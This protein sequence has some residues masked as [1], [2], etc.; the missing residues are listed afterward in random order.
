MIEKR[1]Q[2]VSK[3]GIVWTN[4]FEY[5][6]GGSEKLAELQKNEKVQLKSSN[7][8]NEFRLVK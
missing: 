8:L 6:Q 5:C 2:Y 1:Y 3:G 7:L 4:W